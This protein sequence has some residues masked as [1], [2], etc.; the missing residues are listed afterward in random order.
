MPTFT[1]TISDA[2]VT[3]LQAVVARYN[4]AQGTSLTVKEWVVVQLRHIAIQ[5]ELAA[6]R[7]GIIEQKQQEADAA[8]QL[9]LKQAS[10]SL[11][12]SV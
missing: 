12:A 10:D 8:L 1:I 6:Q 4:A 3:R 11:I 9:A 7:A 2:A 5:D